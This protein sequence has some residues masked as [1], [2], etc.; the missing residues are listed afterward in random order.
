MCGSYLR[1]FNNYNTKEKSHLY[2]IRLKKII[3]IFFIFFWGIRGSTIKYVKKTVNRINKQNISADEVVH[4]A[5][6]FGN[7]VE[8]LHSY[9]VLFDKI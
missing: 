8:K 9:F 2:T 5:L 4:S 3:C 1:L 6:L 7:P